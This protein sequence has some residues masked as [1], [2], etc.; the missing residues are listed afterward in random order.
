MGK[1]LQCCESFAG[2]YLDYIIIVSN[3][4]EEHLMHV[5]LVWEK[6]KANKIYI[7]SM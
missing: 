5:S 2:I 4:W 7:E 6:T 3:T 1:M